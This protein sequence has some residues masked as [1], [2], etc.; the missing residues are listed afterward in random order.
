MT[1]THQRSVFRMFHVAVLYAIEIKASDAAYEHARRLA[2]F[3]R[4]AAYD[5]TVE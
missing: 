4:L 1:V 5:P 2:H 3:V